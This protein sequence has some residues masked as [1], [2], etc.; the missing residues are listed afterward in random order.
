ML[1]RSCRRFP[2]ARAAPE[3]KRWDLHYARSVHISGASSPPCLAMS[4]PVIWCTATTLVQLYATSSLTYTVSL[5]LVGHM[6]AAFPQELTAHSCANINI[7]YLMILP[8]M[9]FW[10]LGCRRRTWFS[11]NDQC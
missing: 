1:L 10:L 4:L 2:T 5:A 6:H 8:L 11:G 3:S 7:G 9:I